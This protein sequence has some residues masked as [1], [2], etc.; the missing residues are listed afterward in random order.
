MVEAGLAESIS[1]ATRSQAEHEPQLDGG[2]QNTPQQGL[3]HQPTS[4]IKS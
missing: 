1:V 3:H 2:D 4:T